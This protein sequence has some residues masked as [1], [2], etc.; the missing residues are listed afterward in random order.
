MNGHRQHGV[1]GANQPVAVN[2]ERI[3]TWLKE[4]DYSFFV[5]NDGDIGGLW[6]NRMFHFLL[7][8]EGSSFQVRGQ[9]NRIAGM[10]QLSAILEFTN[11]WNAD[12]IWPKAFVRVRDDGSV[13]ICADLTIP[14]TSGFTSPQ[15]DLQIRCGLATAAALF[16]SLDEAFPDPLRK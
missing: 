6:D 4:N 2:R 16:D 8:G 5:D 13:V 3:V 11:N 7:L 15:L 10:D 1:T 14:A 12:R 9:W